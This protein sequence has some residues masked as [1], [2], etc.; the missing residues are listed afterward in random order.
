LTAYEDLGEIGARVV[1]LKLGGKE[2]PLGLALKW[3]RPP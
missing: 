2:L 1:A 3:R